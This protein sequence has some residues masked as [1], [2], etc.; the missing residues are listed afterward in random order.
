MQKLACNRSQNDLEEE[1]LKKKLESIENCLN[2]KLDIKENLAYLINLLV[3]KVEVEKVKGN[4]KHVKLKVFYT[5]NIPDID[6]D[7]DMNEDNS[8]QGILL[9]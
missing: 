2:A 7:L 5:F 3:E 4:R 1:K 8:L 6:I 9:S